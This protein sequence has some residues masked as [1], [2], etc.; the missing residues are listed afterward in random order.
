MISEESRQVLDTFDRELPCL[1]LLFAL[2]YETNSPKDVLINQY[3]I[4]R[5]FYTSNII[6]PLYEAI[7]ES[8]QL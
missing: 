2:H 4:E 6:G 5:F 1:L 7:K 8:E 3:T